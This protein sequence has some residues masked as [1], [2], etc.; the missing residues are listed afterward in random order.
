MG[1]FYNPKIVTDDLVLCLDAANKRSY[2]GTGTTWTDLAGSND[3]TLING[4]TFDTTNGGSI[5]LDGT[6]DFVSIPLASLPTPNNSSNF[7]YEAV[8]KFDSL[9]WRTIFSQ[10]PAPPTGKIFLGVHGTNSKLVTFI[11]GAVKQPSFAALS[12][13]TIYH[14]ALGISGSNIYIGLN[15]VWDLVSGS[16][17]SYSGNGDINIGTEP[18]NAGGH[19]DGNVLA[20]RMHSRF[21]QDSELFENYRA[22][23]GRYS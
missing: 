14:V 7:T 11:T 23:K 10:N 13:N 8:V 6:N 17:F 20:V 15:G 9:G 16:A 4:P 21:L 19:V 22:I 3:G 1:I 2:P 18:N 12:T 5:V